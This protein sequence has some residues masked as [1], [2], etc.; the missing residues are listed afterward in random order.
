MDPWEKPC[1]FYLVCCSNQI[2]SWFT[3]GKMPGRLLN[4]QNAGAKRRLGDG[5][6][7]L[8]RSINCHKAKLPQPSKQREM[9]GWRE[10][11]CCFLLDGLEDWR[12]EGEISVQKFWFDAPAG[13]AVRREE[14]GKVQDGSQVM[15]SIGLRG[16]RSDGGEWGKGYMGASG[17]LLRVGRA[18]ALRQTISLPTLVCWPWT[19]SSF[20]SLWKIKR[21]S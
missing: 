21:C 13:A 19:Y 20:V 12:S 7:F 4:T 15:L 10:R 18:Q 17:A 2:P 16:Q 14:G 6:A 9:C 8:V 11:L 3:M 5:A 1:F